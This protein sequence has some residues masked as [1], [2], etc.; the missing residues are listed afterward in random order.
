MKSETLPCRF[1]AV[2]IALL[3]GVARADVTAA[4]TR[5]SVGE[6]GNHLIQPDGLSVDVMDNDFL[7]DTDKYMTGS[8]KAGWLRTFP[9]DGRG[10]ASSFELVG[11]WRALTPTQS[12]TVGGNPLG[13]MVG[14]FADWM[15]TEGAY[16]RTYDAGGGHRV[17]GQ[18]VV[19]G[20]S[21]GNK[22]MRRMHVAIHRAIGMQTSGLEYN[23]Q[24]SGKTW[25]YDALVGDS[26]R[27]G[28][29][30]LLLSLGNARDAAT[31]DS[32]LQ[33][34]VVTPLGRHVG[35]GIEGRLVRQWGS[36]IYAGLDTWRRELGFGL[37]VF[38]YYQPSFKYVS[39]YMPG[40]ERGQFY[41]EILR[42]NV[43]F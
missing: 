34:N 32:Y 8:M 26:V 15:E 6:I 38:R 41:A 39:K 16:A 5:G 25:K 11:T 13:R 12:G 10:Y 24:P 18:M 30:E 2:A 28:A 40:D 7:G 17:K 3:P 9:D 29:T 27:V 31:H 1:L 36:D 43:P 33:G 35:L 20:G 14:R 19:G 22:G 37:T 23:N 21:I 4:A 42:F